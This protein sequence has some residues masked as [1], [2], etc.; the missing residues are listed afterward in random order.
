MGLG[1][2]TSEEVIIDS[3]TGR[4]VTDGTWEY[5]IPAASC[6]PQQLNVTFLKA[7]VLHV[8]ASCPHEHCGAGLCVLAETV[9]NC[10]EV[11]LPSM[12]VPE[13]RHAS[14]ALHS[15]SSDLVSARKLSSVF[16]SHSDRWFLGSPDR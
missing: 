8:F 1:L 3:D 13:W 11:A 14:L 2:H 4:L 15:A 5:K 12:H 9:E 10:P 7:C 6:I 16:I